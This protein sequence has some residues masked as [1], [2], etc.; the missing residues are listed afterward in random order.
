MSRPERRLLMKAFSMALILLLSILGVAF[1]ATNT[2]YHRGA[3]G[4]HP[5]REALWANRPRH[6]TPTYQSPYVGQDSP[7]NPLTQETSAYEDP[8]LTG[9][10][11]AAKCSSAKGNGS[12][13]ICGYCK[14]LLSCAPG[15]VP[16][17]TFCGERA[18]CRMVS[19]EGE[20][21]AGCFPE[22]PECECPSVGQDGRLF[23][24][25]LD[26]RTYF[27]CDDFALRGQ[28]FYRCPPGTH[29]DAQSEHTSSAL[30]SASTSGRPMTSTF[31]ETTTAAPT[32]S[33]CLVDCQLSTLIFLRF[34][35]LV[36]AAGILF[37]L[38][39]AI[40]LLALR[41]DQPNPRQQHVSPSIDR[42]NASPT[43][44]SISSTEG[45]DRGDTAPELPA[46]ALSATDLP[47]SPVQARNQLY[48]T[49]RGRDPRDGPTSRRSRRRHRQTSAS[50]FRQRSFSIPR[51]HLRRRKDDHLRLLS[52]KPTQ[53]PE[54][55][56]GCVSLQLRDDAHTARELLTVSQRQY[57]Q[58]HYPASGTAT[59]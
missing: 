19:L 30:P 3:R 33:P 41:E 56:T 24:D 43:V 48:R 25:P 4:A 36:L 1:S 18:W 46:P 2:V 55:S 10:E 37:L 11:M 40:L 22:C 28:R 34:F 51:A 49:H 14:E 20:S 47:P 12:R 5:G 16:G 26:P 52:L 39:G 27:V 8:K 29:F 54:R 44:V 21:R 6:V 23:P 38:G 45:V 57:Q 15:E 58:H 31:A 9:E 59:S 42:Y 7:A 17:A 13:E 35:P 50:L 53:L 32:P